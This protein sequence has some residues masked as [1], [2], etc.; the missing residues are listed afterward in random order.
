MWLPIVGIPTQALPGLS[1][2]FVSGHP[3]V[4]V[5]FDA[6]NAGHYG[7]SFPQ[8][9]LLAAVSIAGGVAMGVAG[10]RSRIVPRW[11][12]I[13]YP[14]GFLLNVTD[15]PV[16]AWIG[17]TLLALNGTVIAYRSRPGPRSAA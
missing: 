16:V 9:A 4:K 5:V 1:D 11:W 6:F 8:F 3:E 10:W 15:I 17:L 2:V 14:I 13:A 7:A 12:T